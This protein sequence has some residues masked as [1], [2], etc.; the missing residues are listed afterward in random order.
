M[1]VA[2]VGGAKDGE[3]EDH[4]SHVARRMIQMGQA[5]VPKQDELEAPATSKVRTTKGGK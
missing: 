2:Y 5:R 3:V 4:P 1:Q